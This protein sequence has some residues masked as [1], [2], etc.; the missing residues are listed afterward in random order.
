MLTLFGLY[1][2][3]MSNT[4]FVRLWRANIVTD[5]VG[6]TGFDCR[7]HSGWAASSLNPGNVHGCIR[8]D[9]IRLISEDHSG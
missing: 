3:I 8:D 9:K 7:C 1:I 2:N 4:L 5:M 6:L